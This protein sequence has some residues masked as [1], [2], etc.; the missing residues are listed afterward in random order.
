MK[1][2]KS[3]FVTYLKCCS[4][5]EGRFGQEEATS[6]DSEEDTGETWR[7]SEDSDTDSIF[8]LLYLKNI[9]PPFLCNILIKST[10]P[11]H[12]YIQNG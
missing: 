8:Y 3:S 9:R 11:A 12:Y 10:T 7:D 4:W 5:R 2:D 6:N 1:W